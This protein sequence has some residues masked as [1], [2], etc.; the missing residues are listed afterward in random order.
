MLRKSR[1]F[2]LLSGFY[3][4]LYEEIVLQQLFQAKS[5][6]T[7]RIIQRA[8]NT[9]VPIYMVT[10]N[11]VDVIMPHIKLMNPPAGAGDIAQAKIRQQEKAE[12]DNIASAARAGKVILVP[13]N[14]V[15]MEAFGGSAYIIMDPMTGSSSFM[16]T[17]G[18][19][20][21]TITDDIKGFLKQYS[22]SSGTTWFDFSKSNSSMADM[23][24]LD[25]DKLRQGVGNLFDNL[26]H[27]FSQAITKIYFSMVNIFSCSSNGMEFSPVCVTT[28]TDLFI[29]YYN[30][31]SNAVSFY[32]LSLEPASPN[33]YSCDVVNNYDFVA[34]SFFNNP[35]SGFSFDLIVQNSGI[36]PNFS[37]LIAHLTTGPDGHAQFQS[38]FG[39]QMC[40]DKNNIPETALLLLKVDNRIKYQDT[41]EHCWIELNVPEAGDKDI[42][43][44][45]NVDDDNKNHIRDR[46]ELSQV[47]GE[48]DLMPVKVI[49]HPSSS[50]YYY[51]SKILR[52][53][54]NIRL[55]ATADKSN[56]ID[57]TCKWSFESYEPDILVESN[58]L[59]Q[60]F[61]TSKQT[62]DFY[63][64]SC[65]ASSGIFV[66]AISSDAN[67]NSTDI[68]IEILSSSYNIITRQTKVINTILYDLEGIEFTN[69]HEDSDGINVL[70]LSPITTDSNLRIFAQTITPEP[71]WSPFRKEHYPLSITRSIFDTNNYK[72][73]VLTIRPHLKSYSPFNLIL[74][75]KTGKEPSQSQFSQSDIIRNNTPINSI[76]IYTK[77]LLPDMI[78]KL[79]IPFK[80]DTIYN[81]PSNI[82]VF[83]KIS[84]EFFQDVYIT[85]GQNYLKYY[86]T[87]GDTSTYPEKSGTNTTIWDESIERMRF[88]FNIPDL[89]GNNKIDLIQKSIHNY[90]NKNMI[91][92][93]NDPTYGNICQGRG[94][95]GIGWETIQ[96]IYNLG[97]LTWLE[98]SCIDCFGQASSAVA[99][100]RQLGIDAIATKGYAD[101]DFVTGEFHV[102]TST[103]KNNQTG[104]F[105]T[106]CMDKDTGEIKMWTDDHAQFGLL[107]NTY[108]GFYF[109]RSNFNEGWT[110]YPDK[111]FTLGSN[112]GCDENPDSSGS[113][114][115][116]LKINNLWALAVYKSFCSYDSDDKTENIWLKVD[117]S[118]CNGE[119][120]STVTI[121][122]VK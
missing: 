55:W 25:G 6:S 42:Y 120:A 12:L 99:I 118:D 121:I 20:G 62:N 101:Y 52:S 117:Y 28:A 34:K 102:L 53:N 29:K 90:V 10:A 51:K 111:Y 19:A 91:D 1:N 33:L 61:D 57:L 115:T 112:E 66:E 110:L 48:D 83:N 86:N 7:L 65:I 40:G 56:K 77:Y 76:E 24:C 67:H 35:K 84:W 95:T 69:D 46:D 82:F 21:G 88:T 16:I 54:G 2:T 11:N 9:G 97:Y 15:T 104:T 38:D 93:T 63:P 45:A 59:E 107:G 49:L 18:Y 114:G 75:V 72:P 47:K 100:L 44:M 37:P 43:L 81:I 109:I 70:H 4:S 32:L 105:K 96:Y 80:I 108:E 22:T 23:L 103:T 60:F 14:P 73:K 26:A 68:S 50:K 94:T 27:I 64:F 30:D 41:L 92:L 3:G 58:T 106:K 74:N 31:L 113:T 39:S 71:E 8:G 79:T 5:T 122:P 98:N 87:P 116:D 36:F 119:A 89:T 78:Q 85:F 13:Q 17:G